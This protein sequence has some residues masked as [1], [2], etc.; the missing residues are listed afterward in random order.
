ML[1]ALKVNK[2]K[3]TKK[4]KGHYSQ[5]CN[6]EQFGNTFCLQVSTS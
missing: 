3:N 5:N 2:K 6:I 1:K 4:T